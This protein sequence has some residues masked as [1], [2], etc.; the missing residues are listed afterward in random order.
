[1]TTIDLQSEN[2][3]KTQYPA[4]YAW[5]KKKIASIPNSRKYD[6]AYCNITDYDGTGNPSFEGA[7]EGPA[8]PNEGDLCFNFE[9]QL[10]DPKSW[11]A[12]VNGD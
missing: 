4:L 8:D 6:F 9:G 1:M 12:E 10:N 3:L 7:F 5:V 2:E 11:S